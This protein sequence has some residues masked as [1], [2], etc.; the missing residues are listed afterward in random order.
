MQLQD[1]VKPIEDMTDDEL[2]ARL[3]EIR[4]TRNTVRPGGKVRAKKAAKKGM[5]GRVSKVESLLEGLS[6]DELLAL[7]GEDLNEQAAD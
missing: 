7:L 1:L 6:R 2:M 5:Q 3:R 4:H